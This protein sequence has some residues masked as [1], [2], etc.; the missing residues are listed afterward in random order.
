MFKTV[1]GG[2]QIVQQN[3]VGDAKLFDKTLGFDNPRKIRGSDATIDN[4]AGDPEASG[5]DAFLAKMIGGLA[6]EFLDDALELSELFARE[7]LLEDRRERAA[8]FRKKRQITL[9][10]ANV[11]CKDHLCPLTRT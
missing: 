4:R 2:T 7:A 11:P 6:R 1:T 8:F 9:R 5:K 3:D 10:P